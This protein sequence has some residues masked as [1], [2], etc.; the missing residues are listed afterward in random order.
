MPKHFHHIVQLITIQPAAGG[1]H[2]RITLPGLE[3]MRQARL[4]ALGWQELKEM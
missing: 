4:A 1:D 2:H 3:L